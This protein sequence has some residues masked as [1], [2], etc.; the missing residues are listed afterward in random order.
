MPVKD[1]LVL[2]L[3]LTHSLTQT[4]ATG[5]GGPPTRQWAEV[6][7]DKTLSF[8]LSHTHSLTHK[9]M[10]RHRWAADKT[11]G[12]GE[13]R[14]GRS[15]LLE[16]GLPH[17]FVSDTESPPPLRHLMRFSDRKDRVVEL[18]SFS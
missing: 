15:V 12:G 2:S 5:T 9:H 3:S 16:Q 10:H 6:K 17:L 8:S 1:S 14:Q 13:G 7:D 11:V 18:M 4:H